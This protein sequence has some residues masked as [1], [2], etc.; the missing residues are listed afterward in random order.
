[1]SEKKIIYLAGA[2]RGDDSYRDYYDKI[3]HI[4]QKYAEIRTEISENYSITLP[5]YINEVYKQ[6]IYQRDII[7][8]NE[9][10]AIIAEVSGA[11]TGVGYEIAYGMH[12]KKMPVLCLHS[13][14][15]KPSL[16]ITQNKNKFIFI[17]EYNNPK[18][19]EVY[20]KL[21]IQII[22]KIDSIDERKILYK[23]FLKENKIEELSILNIEPYL[24][25][26]IEKY[27]KNLEE[28]RF[29][30]PIE[31]FD[32]VIDFTDR[33]YVINFLLKSIILHK[34]WSD[35]K[36]QQ[37]GTSFMSG[38]KSKIISV[39]ANYNVTSIS[40]IYE[41]IDV[42][43]VGY[44]EEAFKK[45]LRAYRYIGLLY[46][47]FNLKYGGTKLKDEIY[48]QSTLYEEIELISKTSKKHINPSII[49]V[50]NYLLMLNKYL[51][52]Y[53]NE[54]LIETLLE[55]EKEGWYQF[56]EYKDSDLIDEISIELFSHYD[57][58]LEL[59]DYLRNK[60]ELFY[61]KY[62]SSYKLK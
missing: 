59:Y 10:D 11:S 7:W 17:Q 16:M 44:E 36:S 47:P 57:W 13:K 50:T 25:N 51:K 18:D 12:V 46:S 26:I 20:I 40:D 8:I 31:Y 15:S 45:H 61:E 39:L 43:K 23:Y 22:K 3:I 56:I 37:L 27:R 48:L 38:V 29:K 52:K 30:S 35:L 58:F 54:Y 60:S 6:K 5:Q 33:K 4:T 1:M 49:F 14:N 21:F 28:E 19:L 41:K 42:K 9:S 34:K 2:I 55:S 32:E 53:G 24:I 62:Y